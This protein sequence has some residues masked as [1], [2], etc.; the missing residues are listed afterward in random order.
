VNFHPSRD[1]RSHVSTV[2]YFHPFHPGMSV[3]VFPDEM[4]ISELVDLSEVC[5]QVI[6]SMEARDSE[7]KTPA[8]KSRLR[9]VKRLLTKVTAVVAEKRKEARKQ[10]RENEDVARLR[11]Y[12]I[13][14]ADIA[15]AELAEKI[16]ARFCEMEDLRKLM[17]EGK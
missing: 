7:D 1:Q 3:E 2:Q 6:A 8:Y 9:H 15:G 14:V 12:K 10:Q 11:V 4:S 5:L 16:H 13:A 17:E